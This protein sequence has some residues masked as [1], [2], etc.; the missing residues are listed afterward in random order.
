MIY[1]IQY[2]ITSFNKIMFEKHN[3]YHYLFAFSL[4]M[5]VN[6]VGTK[7]K[8]TFTEDNSELELIRKY[9]LNDASLSTGSPLIGFHKP[10]IWIH[11]KYE[12]NARKWKDFMSR[13]T[14]NL[15][16]PYIHLTIQS[17]ID[18]CGDD[19]HICLIDDSSFSKLI[20]SWDVELSILPEPIQ[21]Y[22][23]ELAM[24][25]LLY[26]YGGMIV[27][28]S[29]LC[30]K[31]M[32]SFY[33]NGMTGNRP[34]VCE[35]INRTVNI[36]NKTRNL[37]IA[38]TKIMGSVKNNA[39]ILEFVQYL[40]NKNNKLDF[41]SERQFLGDSSQWLIQ[42]INAQKINLIGGQ[43]IGIKNIQRKQILIDDLFED[44][45]LDLDQSCV[46][47]YIPE[48]ELLVRRKYQW[49]VYLNKNE[50]EHTNAAIVKYIKS[51]K[52]DA[53]GIYNKNTTIPSDTSL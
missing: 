14:N 10:K 49:F 32:K 18:H 40:K 41:T 3:I 20:S 4:I 5:I 39:V 47:I 42:K 9:L 22:F 17:I 28:D 2:Y 29:F 1:Y 50:I 8:Q 21:S 26:I 37:F 16:Q 33:E 45:F 19:F 43:Q 51:S 35:S 38:D 30:T 46:G 48:D 24:M 7:Y 34:F 31:N 36:A 44:T 15:N 25:M 52:V 23:R 27:P 53:S 13:N 12:I 6:Y 11:T